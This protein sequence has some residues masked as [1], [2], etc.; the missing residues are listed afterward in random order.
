MIN[1][2]ISHYRIIE[3]VG[4]GGMGVVYKAE[5]VDLGRYV[6]LKF[7]PEDFRDDPQALGRFQR[8]AKAASV[9]N[10]PNIC[11]IYEVDEQEGR[12]FI[13][14]EFLDGCTLQHQIA[15]RPVDTDF[16]LGLAI[17]IADALDAAH[18]EGIIHR[19][20]KPANIFVTK[21]GHAKVLDFGLAKVMPTRIA[22]LSGTE[23][24]RMVDEEHL[25]SP[26][27][28]LG[29]VPYMSPEQA[30]A[31]ELDARSDLFSFGTVL[32][33]MATGQLP[34]RGDNVATIFDSILNR[35]SVPVVRL[36]PDVPAELE[37]II[38]K[39]LEKD[40]ELR[41]Q[42]AA[43]MRADLQRLKRDRSSG[44]VPAAT[45]NSVT[46]APERSSQ[47]SGPR[48]PSGS[49]PA[50]AV[51]PSPPRDDGQFAKGTNT[52]KGMWL[53]I[54]TAVGILVFGLAVAGVLYYRSHRSIQLTA[55]DTIVLADFSNSTGDSVFDDTLKQALSTR[56][57]ESPFI[58]ILPDRSVRDTL[59][60][61]G[62]SPEERLTAD[63]AR[64]ICQRS[65]SKAMIA[66]SIASLGNAYL[67]GLKAEDCVTGATM[68]VRQEQA[69]SK[70]E[71]LEAVDRATTGLR[72]DLGESLSTIQKFDTPLAQATTPS[73]EALKAYSLGTKTLAIKGDVA[74]IPFYQ[75]AIDLDPNFAMAYASLGTAYGN[76]REGD[77]ATENYQ[78][79]FDL[80]RRVSIRED[81]VISAF[82]YNDVTGDLE[83][84]DQTYELYS[85]AYPR[86]WTP[87]NNLGCNYA[88]LG[89][90]D[91]AV[92][93]TLEANRLGPDA[94]STYEE[95]VEYYCR[96]NRL[97]ES[98]AIY[99][100]AM[101]RH[102]DIPD[103]HTFR[104]GVAFLE[105][106]PDE[107]QR[108]A[109]WAM[110]RPGVEDISLSFQ[111]DTEAYSGH[112]AK[113][114]DL[115]RRA[116]ESAQ[117][118]GENETAA[119]RELNAALREAEFGNLAEGRRQALDAL[120]MSQARSVRIL[121][122]MVLART[123]DT[124]RA[125]KM[126]D[127]LQKQN[128]ANTKM[129]FYWLPVIRAAIQINRRQPERAIEVLQ[130]TV[131][132]ELGLAGPLPEIGALLYPV[133][134][135]GDAYL[136]LHDGRAAAGEFQKFVDNRSMV[137]NSPLGPLARLNLARAYAMQGD[138][139]EAKATYQEF[140]TIWKDADSD[141]PVPKQAKAEYAKLQ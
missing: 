130:T 5:D 123:G 101:A 58:V 41:Y 14:M 77:L 94:G 57:Q 88:S 40:R 9:L 42:T 115:S 134:L 4:G 116:T 127:E 13:V 31:K 56:L 79:A 96:L 1:Q 18:A 86:A 118:A 33:E 76:L 117:R 37:R 89:Q 51:A 45:S 95:L 8:E 97:G 26:G 67:I 80:R 90:W 78:K 72:K 49:G 111:S 53:K 74:A 2:M 125:E 43:E 47:A 102:L 34:F 35:R 69:A 70:D 99:E 132:Y 129:N 128:P 29:T 100:R 19:D 120:T 24:T 85:Q 107:M 25:S 73:L 22:S 121:V 21:R 27:S 133:Y 82:Y 122:A 39:T 103:L 104:Y 23:E 48:P 75:R 126:A 108:Q 141:I 64:E 11:T 50:V 7:L 112:L 131:P 83:K 3:K 20:I 60:L 65:G 140:L 59:K 6:V 71:V 54:G 113:A 55:T 61:M 32:Y 119:K 36:N 28:T 68:T 124:V 10:H 110:G 52:G 136:M 66:G 135:R 138:T 105:R 98:K 12:A 63:V 109:D 30:R 92:K 62:H 44:S 84:S 17:E 93:E 139:A 15:G 91:K 46:V 38:D 114:Q 87:H 137:I 16:L 81:Y 106:D